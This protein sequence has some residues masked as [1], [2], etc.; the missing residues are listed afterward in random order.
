MVP[1]DNSYYAIAIATSL[2]CSDSTTVYP[3]THSVSSQTQKWLHLYTLA[4]VFLSNAANSLDFFSL[5]G[6]EETL[7]N[8]TIGSQIRTG[9]CTLTF[10]RQ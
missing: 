2:Y 7:P 8:L 5:R 1:S 4:S 10:C 6:L 9:I 3:K